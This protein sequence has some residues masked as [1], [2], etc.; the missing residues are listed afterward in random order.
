MVPLHTFGEVSGLVYFVMGYVA[1]E[2]LA[3]R[4]RREG[5]LQPEGARALLAGICDALDYAHRHG[6]VHRD[7]KPDNIL[8]DAGS[9]APLLTDF[10]IAKVP[11]A[12]AQLTTAGQLIGTPHYMSPEQAAG[13][14]D[15]GP[16]SDL[17][18][19][20]VVAYEMLSGRRPFDAENAIDAL[21]QRLTREARPLVAASSAVPSD[22]A[23]AVDRCLQRDAT[24][25]WPDARSLREMLLPSDDES[26]ETP[27]GR[28]LQVSV[29]IGSVALLGLGYLSVYL[30]LNPDQRLAARGLAIFAGALVTAAIVGSV[31][32]LGLCPKAQRQS[33]PREARPKPR[34]WR[35]W[36]CALRRR[37]DVESSS[38]RVRVAIAIPQIYAWGS[39]CRCS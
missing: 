29:R 12:D 6:I 20:G 13:R 34:W 3:G 17:Y 33:I 28:L 5:P 23:L 35:S 27:F 39:S 19:L 18:S 36:Y 1:G 4:L 26:E 25:R 38:P 32:M 37:G 24:K 21:A 14:S 10:G 15:V 22:L 31:A 16:R 11:L 7:I 9:G 8:I 2:S 30:A